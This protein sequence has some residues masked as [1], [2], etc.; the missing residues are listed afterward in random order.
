MWENLQICPK[1]S[2]S[3]NGMSTSLP[4]PKMIHNGSFSEITSSWIF[5]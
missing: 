2:N 4:N 5:Q 1:S 3:S